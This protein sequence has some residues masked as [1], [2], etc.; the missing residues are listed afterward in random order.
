M[1][2]PEEFAKLLEDAAG[3]PAERKARRKEAQRKLHRL[4]DRG[5]VTLGQGLKMQLTA[6]ERSG[7]EW[8]K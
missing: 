1:I 2:T 5:A 8:A 7:P 4:I 3:E 6:P